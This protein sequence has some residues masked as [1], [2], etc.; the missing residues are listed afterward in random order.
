MAKSDNEKDFSVT[1]D[2]G[3]TYYINENGEHYDIYAKDLD[4]IK[5]FIE[6]KSTSSGNEENKIWFS[7]SRMQFDFANKTRDSNSHFILALVKNVFESPEF[8]FLTQ[9]N[10][11][12]IKN[13]IHFH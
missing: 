1:L 5:Y 6:V 7:L 3:N 2:N 4:G 8:L 10:E 13:I 12:F 9:N 11:H